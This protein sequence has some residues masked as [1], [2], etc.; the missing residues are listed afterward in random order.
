MLERRFDH[1]AQAL[2]YDEVNRLKEDVV[3]TQ[4]NILPQG[5]VAAAQGMHIAFFEFI[6]AKRWAAYALCQ[7][8]GK[9]GFS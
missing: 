9:R 6:T 1:H 2:G 3:E 4:V 7:R 5:S 8:M